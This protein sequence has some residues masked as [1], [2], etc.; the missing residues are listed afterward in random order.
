MLTFVLHRDKK[1]FKT[2]EKIWYLSLP[3]SGINVEVVG[4]WSDTISIKIDIDSNVVI[5][6]ET[7]SSLMPL[8]DDVLKH[9]S[10]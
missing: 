1:G 7:F 3:I 6:K 9:R 5:P 8:A 10:V 2:K 4:I